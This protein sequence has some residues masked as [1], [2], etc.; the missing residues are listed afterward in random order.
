MIPAPGISRFSLSAIV[1]T[2]NLP[3]QNTKLNF[4]GETLSGIY[5]GDIQKW[6]DPKL[7]A[8][9]PDLANID[10][11]IVVVHRSDGSGTTYG[12]TDYLSTVSPTWLQKV[13]RSTSVDG[14][15]GLGG[16]GNPGVAGDV[17]QNPYFIG[18]V[19][20]VYAI[21]NKINLAR[22]R[23]RPASSSIRHSTA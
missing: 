17:Q 6:N 23:T 12:S 22:S 13:G 16:S 7:V 9:N 21:Q 4:T 5:L 19:E 15:L 18:Y 14:P 3:N 10:Q 20:L 8:D 1:P 2:Y 11:D